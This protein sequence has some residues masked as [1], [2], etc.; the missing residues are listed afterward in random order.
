ML[1]ICSACS[2]TLCPIFQAGLSGEETSRTQHA[3]WRLPDPHLIPSFT[4]E[5]PS[6]SPYPSRL[7]SHPDPRVSTQP[8]KRVAKTQ[9]TFFTQTRWMVL[10]KTREWLKWKTVIMVGLVLIFHTVFAHFCSNKSLKIVSSSSFTGQ[11]GGFYHS[12]GILNQYS[13]FGWNSHPLLETS[14]RA[15]SAQIYC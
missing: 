15:K 12:V 10:F 5:T 6:A 13:F 1:L 4:Y 11:E 3:Q 9:A 8:S 14:T 7:L 2:A